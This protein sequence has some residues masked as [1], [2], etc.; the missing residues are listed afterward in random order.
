MYEEEKTHKNTALPERR[1]V[2]NLHEPLEKERLVAT[3]TKIIF[4]FRQSTSLANSFTTGS[5]VAEKISCQDREHWK[6]I[7][8]WLNFPSFIC[9]WVKSGSAII[10]TFMLR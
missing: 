8:I 7:K 10:C 9:D 2:G 3:E 1:F 6:M 5:K 4:C